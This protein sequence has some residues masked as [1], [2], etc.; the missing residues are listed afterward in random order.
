MKQSL[1]LETASLQSVAKQQVASAAAPKAFCA[2]CFFCAACGLE[3]SAL[4]AAVSLGTFA[5]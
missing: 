5:G 4:A 1:N 2:A 3:I